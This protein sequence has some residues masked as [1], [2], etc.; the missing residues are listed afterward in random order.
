MADDGEVDELAFGDV[1]FVQ[2]SQQGV[3]PLVFFIALTFEIGQ[4]A[5]QGGVVGGVFVPGG[6]AGE[7]GEFVA[8]GG[9][10]AFHER[11]GDG[12]RKV[13]EDFPFDGFED[14]LVF[15]RAEEALFSFPCLHAQP[16]CCIVA[17]N[18]W[19]WSFFTSASTLSFSPEE[20][21][22]LPSV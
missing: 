21:A 18:P 8:G 15:G 19:V 1:G 20:T 7:F 17:H 10:G 9:L 13:T 4:Q 2:G 6:H 5:G 22:A 14:A 12:G 3:V 11:V 16:A